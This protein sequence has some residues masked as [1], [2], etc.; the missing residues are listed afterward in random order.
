MKDDSVSARDFVFVLATLACLIVVWAVIINIFS[1]PFYLLPSPTQVARTLL[2]D[3]GYLTFHTLITA[4]EAVVGLIIAIAVGFLV[5]TV[6]AN[7]EPVRA[8]FLP[9]IIAAQA[10]P[11][12]AV[13]PIFALW[14]GTG[15]MSKAAM[16]ALLC[17][18]P[19]VM[20]ATRGLL[21]IDPTIKALFEVYRATR[22]QL[23]FKLR[24]PSAVSYVTSGIRISAGLAMIGAI[25][26]EYVGA[27]RG[28]GY[29]ITQATY[30][31]DTDRLFAAVICGAFAGVVIAEAMYNTSSWVFRSYFRR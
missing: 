18:F 5:A 23:F 16:A 3:S 1:I 8:G 26:A 20:N 29:V 13:A 6:L 15:F 31:V 4:A 9:I 21:E 17:W 7:I 19:T 25:V 27:D 30:R 24:L 2:S 12:V 14:F 22:T 10:V 28:L 11:I